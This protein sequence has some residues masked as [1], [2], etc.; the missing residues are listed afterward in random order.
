M[1]KIWERKKKKERWERKRKVWNEKGA[2]EGK[3]TNEEEKREIQRMERVKKGLWRIKNKNGYSSSGESVWFHDSKLT[4]L[5]SWR[6]TK[7]IIGLIVRKIVKKKQK[8]RR[9][10]KKKGEKVR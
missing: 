7:G 3:D 2:E 8:N 5:Y 6:N 1:K 4:F 10:I 9:N